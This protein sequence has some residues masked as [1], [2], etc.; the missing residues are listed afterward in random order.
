M[1]P[2]FGVMAS[3]FEDTR[4]IELENKGNDDFTLSDSITDQFEHIPGDENKR[5]DEVS[6]DSPSSNYYNG[7]VNYKN[8]EPTVL[9][10]EKRHF[11][12]AY[13]SL[14]TKAQICE[15]YPWCSERITYAHVCTSYR[16]PNN[17][18]KSCLMGALTIHNELVNCWTHY[19]GVLFGIA[20]LVVTLINVDSYGAKAVLSVNCL[21]S[22]FMFSSSASFHTFCCH[23]DMVCRRVQ[24]L[25]WLSIAVHTF[26]TNLVVSYM[27]LNE[28]PG[29][30]YGFT[31]VNFVLAVFT[32]GVTYSALQ[33]VYASGDRLS[34]GEV[35]KDQQNSC[36]Q[37]FLSIVE[38]Y[39][40]RA[41]VAMS[42]TLGCLI[43]WI[44]GYGISGVA[45]DH[46]K[47]ICIIY[48]CYGTV[49]FCLLDFPEKFFPPGTFDIMVSRECALHVH[50]FFFFFSAISHLVIILN[51]C[52][53][54]HQGASHQIFHCGIF[55][56]CF[57]VWWF[58]YG[59]TLEKQ[60]WNV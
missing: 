10:V 51:S 35:D 36:L 7:L 46:I 41:L 27:E 45:N 31:V 59:I 21:T 20:S 1:N 3:I 6:G 5:H 9:I 11:F 40:F 16:E 29:V 19:L 2:V 15:R 23:S 56:G 13:P 58:F 4:F 57:L 32:Y 52:Q 49:F 25:D 55:A 48:G 50:L 53:S 43:A 26:S 30:F 39:A 42:Y 33:K 14:L 44:I 17:S 12:G 54:S 34:V 37:R 60:S 22:I 38:S 18:I 28:F 47:L 8:D 24:C